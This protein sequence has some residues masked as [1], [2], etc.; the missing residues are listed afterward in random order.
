LAEPKKRRNFSLSSL[1]EKKQTIDS[2]I[3][4]KEKQNERNEK[5]T[6]EKQK[7]NFLLFL[8]TLTTCFAFGI[9]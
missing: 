7:I 3:K 1:P 6:T 9:K 5:K 4:K 8:Y 2:A